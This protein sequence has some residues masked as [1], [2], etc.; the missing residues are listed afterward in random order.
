[1]A[2]YLNSP[3]GKI[4]VELCKGETGTVYRWF[5]DAPIETRFAPQA[6]QLEVRMVLIEKGLHRDMGGASRLGRHESI[7]PWS[8]IIDNNHAI[9]AVLTPEKQRFLLIVLIEKEDERE[10]AHL[11]FHDRFVR[12]EWLQLEVLLVN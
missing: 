6:A 4:G 1:M 10:F 2:K 9:V 3:I 7:P 12:E 8:N 5:A 11:K